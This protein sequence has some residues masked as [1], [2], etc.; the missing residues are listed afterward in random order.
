[1]KKGIKILLWVVGII[2]ALLLIVS[3][4]AGPVAKGYINKHGEELTGRQVTVGHVGVNLFTGHVAV[5]NLAVAEDS[6]YAAESFAGFDT[7][8]IRVDL[9]RIPFSTI[10]F[11]HITLSGLHASVIQDGE[12]FNF[13]SL[14]EHFA[15][16]T[17]EDEDTTSSN[18]TIRLRNVA[19]RHARLE[20]NDLRSRKSLSLPDVN[21]R[22]PAFE[23]GGKGSSDAGLNINFDRGGHLS[24]D[25][26]YNAESGSYNAEVDLAGFSLRNV[27]G[28]VTDIIDFSS[29]DGNLALPLTASGR[30][31]Q[32]L[33]SRI[34]ADIDLGQVDLKD[35]RQT[36]AALERLQVKVNNINI[37]KN[38]FDIEEVHLSG[39]QA[40]YEQWDG[41]T[42]ISRLMNSR[43]EEAPAP[44]P[45]TTSTMLTTP[46]QTDPS[47]DAEQSAESEKS[48]QQA[49][50]LALRLARLIVE[51]CALTYVNHT[52]PDE[53]CFP[54]TDINV[55]ANNL[56]LSGENNAM[57]RATLPGG[58]HLALR[59]EGNI[60]QWKQHPNLFFTIKGLD[61]RQ[62]SPWAV[63]YTGYPIQDGVFSLTSRNSIN[64]SMLNGQNQLD[65][66]NPRV[67]DKRKDIDASVNVPLKTA[68]YVLRD[69]DDKVLIDLPVK[70]DID[71]PEFNYMKIVWKTLGNLLV[72]VA[73]SP[74]RALGNALGLSSDDLEFI[75][76]DP[77]QHGLTS[78][79]YHTLGKLATIVKS[80]SLMLLILERQM[81]EATN[82]TLV[83]R[84]AML[85]N[86][87]KR[88]MMEQG[89]PESQ[90]RITA[91]EPVDDPK[92]KT[93]YAISSELKLED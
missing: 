87:V 13:S 68:L 56:T 4:V 29:I 5:R 38:S 92:A 75:T 93:G 46:D 15:S 19:L 66:Y 74:A 45:V 77:H 31:E 91:A 86:Q 62:L 50:P 39:L 59:W 47:E 71:S 57:V 12:R 58:G 78:E 81:P 36:V 42:N 53:F 17:T 33:A 27:E 49:K 3:L 23:L 48:D 61:M 1:M 52:L 76:I 7:L 21:L 35:R 90:L 83:R 14:I 26:D 69:K 24:V 22:V 60:N 41:Y 82:D 18:W 84:Y 72:K 6:M 85:D 16:D 64:N 25:A 55:K 2:V 8:D 30:V 11:R 9:L 67:G 44:A 40:T 10:N 70:G 51:N 80:D 34:A 37:D 32:L 79:Q 88:Y 63:A 43:K 89:V 54:V 73:T 28:I 20:Y 65:I